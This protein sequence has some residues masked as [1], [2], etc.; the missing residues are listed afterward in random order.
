MLRNER[1]Y[2]MYTGIYA[3]IFVTYL[4]IYLVIGSIIGYF[5]QKIAK[6]K[7]HYSAGYFWLG[8]FLG[9]IGI[10][11]AACLSDQR[12]QFSP[13]YPAYAAQF[14]AYSPQYTALS[15][16][17]YYERSAQ[18]RGVTAIP[19]SIINEEKPTTRTC[20]ECAKENI[21]DANF[22]RSC[23]HPLPKDESW[24]CSSCNTNN[25]KDA[26]FCVQCGM[27]LSA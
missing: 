25:V 9:L 3:G 10:I 22:C 4:V 14:P 7:G 5:T 6:G 1:G 8:F 15:E 16:K 18:E 2:L 19:Q 21:N 20:P 26:L 24:S 11:I 12:Q 27:K 13:Q 17:P 23:G